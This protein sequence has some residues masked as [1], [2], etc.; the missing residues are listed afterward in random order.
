VDFAHRYDL[1]ARDV[2][3]VPRGQDHLRFKA[4]RRRIKKPAGKIRRDDEIQLTGPASR[5][6]YPAR[7]C[8]VAA[9]AMV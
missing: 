2:F 8:Q 1:P 6:D 5:T 7:M 9:W 4:L 3:R